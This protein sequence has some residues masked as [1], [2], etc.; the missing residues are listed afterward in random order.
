VTWQRQFGSHKRGK[1]EKKLEY[2]TKKSLAKLKTGGG[3]NTVEKPN[4]L[5]PREERGLMKIT[6]LLLS[7][8]FFFF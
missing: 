5:K 6:F 7:F 4:P 3:Y 2:K 1:K 8:S